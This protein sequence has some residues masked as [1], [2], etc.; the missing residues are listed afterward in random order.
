MRYLLILIPT[1][2][3]LAGCEIEKTED[4][5]MPSVEVEGGKLPKYDVDAPD[6]EIGSKEVE[7]EVPDIDVDTERKTITVPTVDI[8]GPNDPEDDDH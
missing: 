1:L 5:E 2:L 6:I 8:Q 7:V 3:L 4:G